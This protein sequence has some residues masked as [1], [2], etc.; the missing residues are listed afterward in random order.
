MLNPYYEP[1]FDNTTL[2]DISVIRLVFESSFY[3]NTIFLYVNT[4]SVLNQTVYCRL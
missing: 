3:N 4:I 1:R 2:I